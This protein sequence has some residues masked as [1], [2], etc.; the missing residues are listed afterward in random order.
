[1]T[2]GGDGREN[3]REVSFHGN[4]ALKSYGSKHGGREMGEYW[5]TCEESIQGNEDSLWGGEV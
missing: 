4:N 3:Q 2:V 5:L 1:M